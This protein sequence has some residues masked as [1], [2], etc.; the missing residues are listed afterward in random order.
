ML[1]VEG[2]LLGLAGAAA[3]FIA[4]GGVSGLINALGGLPMPP[5][6]GMSTSGITVSFTPRLQSFFGNGVWLVLASLVAALFPG[7]LSVRR[8]AAELLRS[9]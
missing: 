7:M 1:L 3:G 2:L 9:R 6:P 4:G 5:E 8:T